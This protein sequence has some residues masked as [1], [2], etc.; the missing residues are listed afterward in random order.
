MLG[1]LGYVSLLRQSPEATIRHGTSGH[2]CQQ[3]QPRVGTQFRLHS[4]ELHYTVCIY[5]ATGE[6]CTFGDVALMSEDCI[7]TASVLTEEPSDLIVFDRDL[8]NRSVKC[9]LKKEFDDK[10]NFI[11]NSRYFRYWQNKYRKQLAMAMTKIT[12]PYEATI[13]K[14]GQAVDAI[15]F[16]LT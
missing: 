16:L 14:Q 8:Y 13:T 9:V 10:T 11:A 2:Y 5:C 6:N 4:N 1:L 7:R 3:P 12:M 15:Y